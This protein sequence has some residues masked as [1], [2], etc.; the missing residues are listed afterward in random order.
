[1]ALGMDGK[2]IGDFD[3]SR[4][5]NRKLAYITPQKELLDDRWIEWPNRCFFGIGGVGMSDRMI[6]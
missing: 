6:F 4:S 2:S 3:K 5:M 1:M